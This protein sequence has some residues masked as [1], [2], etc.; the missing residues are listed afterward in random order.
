METHIHRLTRNPDVMPLFMA[1][2]REG[3]TTR[4]L[5]ARYECSAFIIHIARERLGLKSMRCIDRLRA[6]P[7][8]YQAFVDDWQLGTRV[9]EMA[10]KYGCAL[11][12]VSRMAHTIGLA[13]RRNT[14]DRRKTPYR[15]ETER[16]CLC[17]GRIFLSP[18]PK[19]INRICPRCSEE[20]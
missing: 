16:T 11:S 17:C 9:T 13:P 6:D 15:E 12:E 1:D 14:D 19:A 18:H 3:F 20:M 5:A 2:I 8:K 10:E 7:E 4:E